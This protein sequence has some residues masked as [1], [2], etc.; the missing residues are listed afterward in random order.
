MSEDKWIQVNWS[1]SSDEEAKKVASIIIT[2][3]LAACA[4]IMPIQSLFLWKGNLE[5]AEERLVIFK[6]KESKYEKIEDVIL[7]NAA[8]EVPEILKIPLLGG[9]KTYLDWIDETLKD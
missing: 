5:K 8:Y 2:L 4:H 7:K 9:F 6:T 3:R 1:A